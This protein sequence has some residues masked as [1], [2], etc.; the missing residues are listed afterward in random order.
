MHKIPCTP[1][2][3]GNAMHSIPLNM[4]HNF[5]DRSSY[6]GGAVSNFGGAITSNIP[7]CE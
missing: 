6:A 4:H 2:G 5:E 7:I 1:G 3:K